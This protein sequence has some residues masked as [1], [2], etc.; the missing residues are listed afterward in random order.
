MPL[1]T[2]QVQVL[3]SSERFP[4]L[5][6]FRWGHSLN[7]LW[8]RAMTL[9][10]NRIRLSFFRRTDGLLC[11]NSLTAVIEKRLDYSSPDLLYF[12]ANGPQGCRFGSSCT[13]GSQI[14]ANALAEERKFEKRVQNK[15]VYTRRL[16]KGTLILWV[17]RV[18][19]RFEHFFTR[20]IVTV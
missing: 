12:Y 7:T 20:A 10:R 18:I 1:R 8:W 4:Y 3:S 6:S 11:E 15:L 2:R 17:P 16:A 5:P 13:K 9:R 14:E 19:M